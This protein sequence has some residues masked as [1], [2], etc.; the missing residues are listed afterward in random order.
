[1][2]LFDDK[3]Q[4]VRVGDRIRFTKASSGETLTAT[5]VGLHR[6]GN[7]LS[8]ANAFQPK[9]LGFK[10]ETAHRIAEIMT[11][12]YTRE[13]T[14]KNGTLAIRISLNAYTVG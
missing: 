2:R 14:E 7:F 1:M 12:I 9:E 13:E 10:G 3:R 11:G 6:F 4:K 8:L 5:V